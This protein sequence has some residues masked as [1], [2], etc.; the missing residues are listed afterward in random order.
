ML[1]HAVRM[2]YLAAGATDIYLESGD[3]SIRETLDRLWAHMTTYQLYINGAT[4]AHHQYE[5]FGKDYLLPNQRAY[6]E[7]CA[8]IAS[9]MWNWR[10]LML[11]GDARYA[12]LLEN[13][14]FNAVLPGFGLDRQGYFYENPLAD[15]GTHRRQPWF[16]CA[17]CPPNL[18]RL[19]ATLPGY[20]YS[21]SDEGI[22]VHLYAASQVNLT[23]LDGRQVTVEQQCSYPW[24]GKIEISIQGEGE[25]SLV[26]RIPA[27]THGKA[28]LYI[29]QELS[30]ED[31]PAGKYVEVR[32][33]WKNGDS[34]SLRLPMTVDLYESHPYV[35]ENTGKAAIMRGPLLY[36]LEG[37]DHP[38]VDL[39]DLT[40]DRAATFTSSFNHAGLGEIVALTAPAQ[41]CPPGKQWKGRLHRPVENDKQE[42]EA[43][44]IQ[45]RAIPYF[46]W[47]NRSP[48]QMLVW[49]KMQG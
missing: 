2:L 31:L 24:E 6:A 4:G 35:Q 38:G 17:C 37:V 32:R 7:T 45:A 20:F 15:D 26:L 5:S 12:D 10:M 8:A 25:F 22:W 47:A 19:L 36:C 3:D 28:S 13:T 16:E 40:F 44:T 1:G 27:Y 9:V 14:L 33:E 30:R 43:K 11:D 46:A 34:V 23:L 42:T 39:R 29:N 41:F 49:V 18:A 48:G 21:L